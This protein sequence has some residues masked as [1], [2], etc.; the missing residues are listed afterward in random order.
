MIVRRFSIFLLAVCTV[1]VFSQFISAQA[2]RLPRPSPGASVTQTIGV[3]DITITYSRP[4]VKGRTDLRRS[5]SLDGRP[6]QRRC[7]AGQPK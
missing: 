2:L 5:S 1:L 3:T 4:P 7:H 6:S